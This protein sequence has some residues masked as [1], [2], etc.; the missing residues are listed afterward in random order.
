MRKGKAFTLIEL[1]VV[2][3]IVV[4]LVSILIPT[5]QFVR[6]QAKAAMCKINLGQWGLVWSMYTEQNDSKFPWGEIYDPN[7]SK[8]DP[9]DWRTELVDFYSNDRNILLC[10]MTTRTRA[11]GA[12]VKYAITVDHIWQQKS[13]YAINDWIFLHGARGRTVNVRY[14]GTPNA[15]NAYKVPVMGD[16]AYWISC[17]PEPHDL[18]PLY[19]GNGPHRVRDLMSIFCIDRHDGGINVLFMDWSVRKVGLKELWTLKWHQDFDTAGPWTKA[20][21]VLPEDWPEWM[22]KFKD[23]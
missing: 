11:E 14:W 3:S 10:P 6:R 8:L 5:V 13:S 21:G 12:P 18:P 2:I 9:R 7:A 22:R 19:D 1:L 15:P 4:L 16:S 23:Y 20:G 17:P